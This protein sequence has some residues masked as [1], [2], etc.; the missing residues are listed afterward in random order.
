MCATFVLPAKRKRHGRSANR[1]HALASTLLT[2]TA[3][4]NERSV[5]QQ[6]LG[7]TLAPGQSMPRFASYRTC[8][9]KHAP[10]E[11]WSGDGSILHRGS[12][13]N[14]WRRMHRQWFGAGLPTAFDED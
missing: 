13:L 10:E 8:L 4:A 3:V 6:S 9:C 12:R 1:F 2:V 14:R 7:E 11:T 5:L